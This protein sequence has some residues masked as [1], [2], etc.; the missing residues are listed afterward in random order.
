MKE[1]GVECPSCRSPI[2]RAVNPPGRGITGFEF[3]NV[4]IEPVQPGGKE[5]H[6]AVPCTPLTTG[7]FIIS[8]LN[9]LIQKE[10]RRIPFPK[11]YLLLGIE[12]DDRK[13]HEDKLIQ[14]IEFIKGSTLDAVGFRDSYTLHLKRMPVKASHPLINARMRNITFDPPVGSFDIM[15]KSSTGKGPQVQ[16]KNVLKTTT[17]GLIQKHLKRRFESYP[18]PSFVQSVKRAKRCRIMGSECGEWDHTKAT[19]EDLCVDEKRSETLV[20]DFLTR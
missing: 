8:Y 14:L 12:V 7:E 18:Y 5:E 1:F 16:F 17:L 19:L 3:V 11:E 15:V 20:Y 9:P 10:F 6:I 13:S 4:V 2:V